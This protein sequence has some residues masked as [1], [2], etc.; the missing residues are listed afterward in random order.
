MNCSSDCDRGSC[1]FVSD[2]RQPT[3]Y[4]CLKC[5]LERDINDGF[6]ISHLFLLLLI[7]PLLIGLFM[8]LSSPPPQPEPAPRE[9][10]S[11]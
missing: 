11:R 2:P 10:S 4:V 3:R 6:Q 8:N 1:P 7:S 9:L 5:G